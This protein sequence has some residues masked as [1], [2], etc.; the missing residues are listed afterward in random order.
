M[1]T[2]AKKSRTPRSLGD[3][4]AHSTLATA[5]L[6]L[7]TQ[8]FA[9]EENLTEVPIS[10]STISRDAI[11]ELNVK[12]LTQ[13]T[14]ITPAV[15]LDQPMTNGSTIAVRGA[16]NNPSILIDGR[17]LSFQGSTIDLMDVERVEVLRG[18]QASLFGNSTLQ[19]EQ[20]TS[21]AATFTR[22]VNEQSRQ[23]AASIDSL[24]N[25]PQFAA[26]PAHTDS[27]LL[28]NLDNT[29]VCEPRFLADLT[30]RGILL[31]HGLIDAAQTLHD[32]KMGAK[33][34]EFLNDLEYISGYDDYV[35][36][37][38]LRFDGL[39]AQYALFNSYADEAMNADCTTFAADT[40]WQPHWLDAYTAMA[41]PMYGS[42][43]PVADADIGSNRPALLS[44]SIEGPLWRPGLSGQW[45][46]TDGLKFNS[47]A[48]SDRL[49]GH[50]PN[51][52]E[53][54]SGDATN[55]KE[56][57]FTA[58]LAA[59]Y[60][61]GGGLDIQLPLYDLRSDYAGNNST[62]PNL[63]QNKYWEALDLTRWRKCDNPQD[64]SLELDFDL[65]LSKRLFGHMLTL[66]YADI[67]LRP[68]TN[69]ANTDYD[70]RLQPNFD[71]GFRTPGNTA[72]DQRNYDADPDYL[73]RLGLTYEPL[74][75]GPFT[76]SRQLNYDGAQSFTFP[77]ISP[78]DLF[79]PD[80]FG[81]DDFGTFRIGDSEYL[82]AYIDPNLTNRLDFAG[83]RDA[84]VFRDPIRRP[85]TDPYMQT[86]QPGEVNWNRAVDYQWAIKHVGYVTGTPSA[87][88]K[89]DSSDTT[90][91]VV[92]VIDTGLDW[93]HQDLAAE[94]LWHNRDEIAGN[95]IDD[96]GNGYVDDVMG[97]DFMQRDGK[98][99]DAHGHGTMVA[100]IIAAT[101]N[102]NIGIAGINPAAQI[103][104]LKVANSV[105]NS[106]ASY[107]AEAITYAADNGANIIN[108]S[109]GGGIRSTLE[110]QAITY[111]SQRGVLIVAAA[112]NEGIALDDYGPGA[113]DQVFTVAATDFNDR[114]A[115]FSNTG[116]AVDI[117][118]PG[119]DV[120]SLRARGT[121]VNLGATGATY[122]LGDNY[123]GADKRYIHASGTSFAAPIVSGTASAMLA[124][125]PG[126]SPAQLT[127]RL[128]ETA[129]DVELP[130][131]D[132]QTG[133]GLVDAR[134]ALTVDDNFY[135]H[136][137]VD[138]L[139]PD[140]VAQTLAI[141][142]IAD[143]DQFKRAWLQIGAGESPESWK[144]VG[145]KLKRPVKQG[146]LS[147]VALS[148]FTGEGVWTVRL[149]V[150][151]ASGTVRRA[152]K[153]VRLR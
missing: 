21:L 59:S 61:S 123:L 10:I 151:H 125:E 147:A 109:M 135:V 60:R 74:P 132:E 39:K 126:L 25:P 67:A 117:A 83:L 131:M 71:L 85:Q 2:P 7:A 103:M 6:L 110:Q 153:A 64:Y 28:D 145:L 127:K 57:A 100:G 16:L 43:G 101:R 37:A 111:A 48:A 137:S 41:A 33:Y 134:T 105:G 38:Q 89:L 90:P 108:I 58:A 73:P 133:A 139:V 44:N 122:H 42:A 106:N 148:E 53:P 80:C 32:V 129:W 152:T 113:E 112:G 116:S 102:N 15:R 3:R 14:T 119:V 77:S 34:A 50:I 29:N 142:G 54:Y 23:N 55:F 124:V 136:A 26:I 56:Y 66:G 70:L 46:L 93:H 107:I 98:P 24:L 87:W 91:V 149:N 146:V 84:G 76:L 82:R 17:P 30:G 35:T 118:A 115:E 95:G 69:F 63:F 120:L 78:N 8:A 31:E 144:F 150:E 86:A 4:K 68:E 130:G 5:A 97:Y 45:S 128:Q 114:H 52:C 47:N 140:A 81:P 49:N 72:A 143:A 40:D 20:L 121:D 96:D 18:P 13:F 75:F 1:R 51:R 11:S 27:G 65:D 62:E 22:V 99:W 141:H 88:S 12:E 94:N 92:A 138:K 36:Q 104:V 79:M 19:P 9:R